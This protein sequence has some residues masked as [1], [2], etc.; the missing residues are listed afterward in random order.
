MK[1]IAI[2]QEKRKRWAVGKKGRAQNMCGICYVGFGRDNK[3]IL[4]RL[5]HPLFSSRYHSH[6][7]GKAHDYL[8]NDHGWMTM[9]RGT[10]EDWSSVP[11]CKKKVYCPLN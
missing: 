10:D 4:T 9:L 5:L 8:I 2:H 7:C 3:Y 6:I 1:S 11:A